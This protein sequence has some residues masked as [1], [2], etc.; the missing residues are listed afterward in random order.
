MCVER[1]WMMTCRDNCIHYNVCYKKPDHFD[2]LDVNG[3]CS[4]FAD[5]DL[6]VKIPCKIGDVVY[7]IVDCENPFVADG[8]VESISIQENSFWIFARY[9][10][11]LTYWHKVGD[12]NFFFDEK[13]ANERCLKN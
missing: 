10:C 13:K 7:T 6:N 1:G 4:D 12:K 5:N 3:G 11:G 8:K 2:D 9:S